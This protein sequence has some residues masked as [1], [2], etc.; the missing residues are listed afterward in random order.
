LLQNE[1][2][3]IIISY[4]NRTEPER[5]AVRHTKG[6]PC[7]TGTH[8]PC[9][10]GNRAALSGFSCAPQAVCP[11]YAEPYSGRV[12]RRGLSRFFIF[13]S[14]GVV[15]CTARCTEN[16]VPPGSKMSSDKTTSLKLSR[17]RSFTR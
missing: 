16:G 2:I 15:G 9:Q 1:R 17:I 3:Y 7:A 13:I 10:A 14:G 8:E 5:C 6:G 11:S 12:L 4:G